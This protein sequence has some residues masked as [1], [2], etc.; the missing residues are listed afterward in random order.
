MGIL[1]SMFNWAYTFTML[2]AGPFVDWVR[3]RIA[4]PLAV[5]FWS[6]A[7]VLCGTTVRFGPLGDISGT[8]RS[9]RGT[10]ARIRISV[11]YETFPREKR[12]SAVATFFSGNKI[13]LAFGIPFAAAVYHRWGLAAIFYAAGV[14]SLM[15]LPWFLLTYQGKERPA[16][17]EKSTIRWITLLKYRT[18]WGAML[19]NFGY[20]Y[21][22]FVFASWLPGYLVLQRKMSVI[23]ERLCGYASLPGWRGGHSCRGLYQRLVGEEGSACY[24]RPQGACLW[25]IVH[26]DGLH[27]TGS[28][29]HLHVAG[30]HFSY[31]WR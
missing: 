12:A 20:L 23:V 28:L 22:Y 24:R 14:L 30:S 6:V 15:W 26:G 11:I 8:G 5:S 13:G 29:Y 1:L 7:T 9:G 17:R 18:T 10:D 31:A 16:T 21:V 19:G 3:A 4:Y 27:T 25:W 2:G